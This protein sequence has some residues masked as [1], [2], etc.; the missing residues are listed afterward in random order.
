[1]AGFAQWGEIR[2][3]ADFYLGRRERAVVVA[4]W[5]PYTAL[6]R[7][8]D[9]RRLLFKKCAREMAAALFLKHSRSQ[10]F[11]VITPGK[12]FWSTARSTRGT[13]PSVRG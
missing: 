2:A 3:R 1:M 6:H 4:S 7:L 5:D 13:G 11:N 9:R 12:W 10:K 8:D